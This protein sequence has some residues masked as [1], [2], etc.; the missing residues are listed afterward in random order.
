MSK[1]VEAKNNAT[2]GPKQRFQIRNLGQKSRW[3]LICCCLFTF[4]YTKTLLVIKFCHF[5]G[6]VISFSALSLLFL[7]V[8]YILDL[9]HLFVFFLNNG[10]KTW[11]V[12]NLLRMNGLC[13][14]HY[15]M[16]CGICK[17][18]FKLYKSQI[19]ILCYCSRL[20][21]IS[22]SLV[23]KARLYGD[24]CIFATIVAK[25]CSYVI[26]SLWEIERLQWNICIS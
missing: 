21:R 18:R 23:Y 15:K 26:S 13:I 9:L 2:A 7:F 25:L 14:R 11:L 12:I 22:R 19:L 5:F 8:L 20:N 24:K 16:S 6:D 10:C 1:S 3:L 4:F 17:I